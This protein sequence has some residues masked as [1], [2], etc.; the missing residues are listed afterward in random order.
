M[1]APAPSFYDDLDGTLAEAW[2]LLGRGVADRRSPFH[3]PAVATIGLDG[4]PQVR[5]VI[6]RGCDVAGRTLRFHTD[7]RSAKVAE[8]AT[9]SRVA[10]HFYDPGHKIQLRVSGEAAAHRDD[11]IADA[12]WAG[13]RLFSRQCYGIAP[14]PGVAIEAGPAFAL[15][16]VTEDATADGRGNFVA[17]TLAIDEL[18]WLYLAAAGHRRA[19]FTWDTGAF[20]ATWLVP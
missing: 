5:T 4:R 9:Q 11:I 7:R 19:R 17:V 3:H 13:S 16:D 8:I 1:N 6:L 2:R 12:A 18:E 15:P 14:G 10:M 20:S